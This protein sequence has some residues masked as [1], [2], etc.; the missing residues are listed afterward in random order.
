MTRGVN[1]VI[2]LGHLGGDPEVKY[3]Q[4]GMA[5]ARVSLATTSVRKDRD[6][7]AQERTEWH[8]VVFFGKLADIAADYLRKGRQVYIE[9][10]L[11]Y[12]T[13]TGQDGVQK[14]STDICAE[15]MQM[16][17][18]RDG[19]SPSNAGRSP[20]RT[21]A[22]RGGLPAPAPQPPSQPCISQSLGDDDL[23]F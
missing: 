13:F 2:L 6:G 10:T 3:T 9:G 19:S 7:N 1:K 23:P 12:D 15:S 22:H 14:Y 8:R 20:S 16:L 5:V 18:S 4:G 17:G 21:R 11:R